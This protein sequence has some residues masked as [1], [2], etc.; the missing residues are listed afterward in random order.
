MM[1]VLDDNYFILQNIAEQRWW[2]EAIFLFGEDKEAIASLTRVRTV[3]MSCL[4]GRECG[5]PFLS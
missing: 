2:R 5:A 3:K 4:V 1:F